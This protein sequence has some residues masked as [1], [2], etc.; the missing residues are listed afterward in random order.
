MQSST[1]IRINSFMGELV[2]GFGMPG[3]ERQSAS[4]VGAIDQA[5]HHDSQ[6]TIV[7]CGIAATVLVALGRG[8]VMHEVGSL[9][10][11]AV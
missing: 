10:C 8:G 1:V 4:V 3:N 2:G 6:R 5:L 9:E 7:G 11:V